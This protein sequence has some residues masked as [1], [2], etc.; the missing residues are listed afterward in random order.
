MTSSNNPTGKEPFVITLHVERDTLGILAAH[1]PIF[2]L[3]TQVCRS[4]L[5]ELQ[6]SARGVSSEDDANTEPATVLTFP[7]VVVDNEP[8]ESPYRKEAREAS[9]KRIAEA[10][11]QFRILGIRA[12]RKWRRKEYI[13]DTN[14]WR[15]KSLGD[16]FNADYIAVQHAISLRR[17][18]VQT[19]IRRRRNQKIANLYIDGKSNRE[20]AAAVGL[21]PG[22]I[23]KIL[24]DNKLLI[25]LLRAERNK[26]PGGE[27]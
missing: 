3:M 26:A 1:S 5:D 8:E 27:K 10:K 2:E 6:R 22:S 24:K 23:A 17:D 21:S 19:Y 20:I 9:E 12:Y 16:F 11:E 4:C 25:S 7:R 18:K 15:L 13:G 14:H